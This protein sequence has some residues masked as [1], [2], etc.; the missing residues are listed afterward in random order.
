MR[1]HEESGSMG[2]ILGAVLAGGASRRMG[3]DKALVE[4]AGRSLLMTATTVLQAVFREVV[5][6]GSRPGR[7]S[8]LE[9]QVIPD[10]RPGL[11]PLAGIHAALT[12]ADGRDV[13]ILACDLPLVTSDLVRRIAG[14]AIHDGKPF[15]VES[16]CA[17]AA[18]RVARDRRGPQPLCGL[19]RNCCLPV[20]E[21]ALNEGRLSALELIGEL[22]TECL[23]VEEGD[24]GHQPGPLTN[25]NSPR[26]L[27]DLAGWSEWTR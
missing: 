20:V 12:H 10:L 23:D 9:I 3:T 8:D 21:A 13:F 26:D 22:D 18:V 16:G 15:G 4:V 19:F 17:D 25:V 24:L 27:E 6:V 2:P 14:A 5:V 11:G 7:K 1:K